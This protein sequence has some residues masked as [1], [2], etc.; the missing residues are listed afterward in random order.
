MYSMDD[1]YVGLYLKLNRSQKSTISQSL[2]SYR[3]L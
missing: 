1:R 2:Y 3:Y